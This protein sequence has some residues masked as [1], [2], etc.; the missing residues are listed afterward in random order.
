MEDP[1]K[2]VSPVCRTRPPPL[3]SPCF[4]F[5]LTSLGVSK[6]G[7]SPCRLRLSF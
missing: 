5:P 7:F 6:L 1:H 4:L 2:A 3:Q